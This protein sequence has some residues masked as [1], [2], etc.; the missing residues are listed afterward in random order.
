MKRYLLLLML[1]LVPKE[2]M[3]S[4]F[5]TDY[6]LALKNTTKFYEESDLL[7]REEIILYQNYQLKRINENYY[8]ENE[9]PSKAPYVDKN[10][11]I[12]EY[13]DYEKD[14]N[15]TPNSYGVG[16]IYTDKEIFFKYVRLS[17]FKE[18]TKIKQLN[19]YYDD[20]LLNYTYH[21]QNDKELSSVLGPGDFVYFYFDDSYDIKRMRFEFI[22]DMDKSV[23]IS[24]DIWASSARYKGGGN[25][26]TYQIDIVNYTNNYTFNVIANEEFVEICEELSWVTHNK[27]KHFDYYKK[28]YKLYKYYD[29]EKEY[30][31]YYSK[32]AQV[33]YFLDY[34]KKKV[35]YNY[36]K[37]DK[38]SINDAIKEEEPLINAINSTT[39]DKNKIDLKLDDDILNINYLD[40]SFRQRVN[41]IKATLIEEKVENKTTENSA[42][43]VEDIRKEEDTT[44]NKEQI[45]SQV[46]NDKITSMTKTTTK[47]RKDDS[48]SKTTTT[49]KNTL[50]KDENTNATKSSD[51]TTVKGLDSTTKTVIKEDKSK[52]YQQVIIGFGLL[53]VLLLFYVL[54][55]KKKI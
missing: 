52:N 8:L 49:A 7:K 21:A 15:N 13:R 42:Q 40:Y 11:F 5:Y 43:K 14:Y 51:I 48:I 39:L 3:A 38:I 35:I 2:I 54:V 30:I 53:S 36:Y 45:V 31:D 12:Y 47:K 34:D 25:Y 37:R 27:V 26:V 22:F 28:P 19:I 9:N 20:E 23:N 29:L 46:S 32:E 55:F 4:V 16:K 41:I 44:A 10:D 17:N 50:I 1:L 18:N 24:F 33:D 6:E